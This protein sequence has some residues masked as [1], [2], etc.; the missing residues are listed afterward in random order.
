M[1]SGFT[2]GEQICNPTHHFQSSKEIIIGDFSITP[3][4]VDHSG[5]D[6]Y[7]FIIKANNKCIIYTGDF[8]DHGRKKKATDYFRYNIPKEV[9]ALL[10]EGTMMN[11]INE[12]IATEEQI[13]IKAYDFMKSKQAPVFVLQSS[14]NIDRL[15]GMYR[16]A[17]RSRCIFVMDIFTAHIVSQLSDTIPKPGKF[18]DVRVFY[19]YYLTKRM[20]KEIGGERL[21]KQF[22]QY[23]ISREDLGK[24]ND[25]CM[26]IRDSML[27]DLQHIQNLNDAGF[28]YSIWSGYKKQKRTSE[29]LDYVEQKNMDIIDLHTSGH[30]CKKSLQKMILSIEAK[31][32]I[33]IHTEHPNLFAEKFQRVYIAKD[34]EVIP[35]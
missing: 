21:M 2:G 12:T 20:Y 14:T 3:Y 10:I 35:I 25:Y 4:L 19:P 31:K 13:E 33:P 1:T 7:A 28:I 8:R 16:A 6:A 11:R 17:K 29:I 30:A 34:K 9:D 5:Y 18:K 24:R 22:S 15:V 26:L 23:R 32:V 27:S